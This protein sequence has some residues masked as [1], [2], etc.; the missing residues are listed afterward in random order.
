MYVAQINSLAISAKRTNSNLRGQ[1]L[2]NVD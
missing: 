2:I 1:T